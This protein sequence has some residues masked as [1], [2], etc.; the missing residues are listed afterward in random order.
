MARTSATAFSR[1]AASADWCR[2]GSAESSASR[3]RSMADSASAGRVSHV[4]RAVSHSFGPREP[5]SYRNVVRTP[6]GTPT[7]V[8]GATPASRS[9]QAR[10][11]R[12]RTRQSAPPR[13]RTERDSV[14]M[15]I[16]GAAESTS[17]T[18]EMS[19]VSSSGRPMA[20]VTAARIADGH[21]RRVG[22]V[23]VLTEQVAEVRVVQRHR[24]VEQLLVAHA[25]TGRAARPAALASAP[26]PRAA[27]AGVWAVST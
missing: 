25:P 18:P 8:V 4:G 9:A 11:A 15:A 2:V 7:I 13:P 1:S 3:M 14:H 20:A 6:I 21:R 19:G 23:E 12:R 24:P 22:G 10:H 5:N 27:R 16:D 17:P 26:G